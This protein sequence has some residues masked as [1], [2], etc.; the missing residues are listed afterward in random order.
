MIVDKRTLYNQITKSSIINTF[1]INRIID[2]SDEK[3]KCTNT[4]TSIRENNSI[5]YIIESFDNSVIFQKEE[6]MGNIVKHIPC[7]HSIVYSPNHN[8][9]VVILIKSLIIIYRNYIFVSKSFIHNEEHKNIINS[10]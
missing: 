3:Y 8:E 1:I 6:L 4:Y 9:H 7:N 2:P 10:K 5:E